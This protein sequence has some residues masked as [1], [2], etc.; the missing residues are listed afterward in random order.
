MSPGALDHKTK[1]LVALGAALAAGCDSWTDF[2]LAVAREAKASEE[3]IEE[4]A[5][6]A[7]AVNAHKTRSLF[8]KKSLAAHN[9]PCQ[10]TSI[11][12]APAPGRTW[13]TWTNASVEATVTN[14]KTIATSLIV[15][16]RIFYEWRIELTIF[17]PPN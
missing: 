16:Q 12:L 15:F 11:T 17:T 5:A 4:V 7:M 10:Q 1:Q 13:G 8:R 14:S 9:D 3:E 6:I 2:G